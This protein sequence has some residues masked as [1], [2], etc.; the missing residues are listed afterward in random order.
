MSD[1]TPKPAFLPTAAPL[2]AQDIDPPEL[3]VILAEAEARRAEAEAALAAAQDHFDA[4]ER[5]HAYA[6]TEE[7][8]RR[9]REEEFRIDWM[10][11]LYSAV[12]DDVARFQ[13]LF[14]QSCAE[15]TISMDRVV[16]NFAMWGRYRAVEARMRTEILRYDGSR[17]SETYELWIRRIAGWNEL[18]RSVTSW[19]KGGVLAGED[20]NLEGLAAVNARINEES[21]D[22]PRPL[23]RDASD[24]STPFIE[25]LGLR[26]P[27]NSSIDAMFSQGQHALD[28]AAEFS[29]AIAAGTN[30]Y[31]RSVVDGMA[32]RAR[33]EFAEQ[34]AS[35]LAAEDEKPK[36]KRR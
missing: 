1:T 8:K 36:G 19:R 2:P 27:A 24:L 17:S 15:E 6:L 13:R 35:S 25:D 18:I 23:H 14:D 32:D 30:E 5:Q 26:S 29:R 4:A 16:K 3:A 33:S 22:A 11:K 31:A 28:F 12:S 7:Q 9:E 20:D 10:R 34:A 21:N